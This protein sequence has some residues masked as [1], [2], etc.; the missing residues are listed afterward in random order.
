MIEV[1]IPKE[2]REYKEKWLVGMTKRQLFS[3]LLGFLVNIPLY[4]FLQQ[5]I[6][7]ELAGW[8]IILMSAPFVLIGFKT[9][10]GMPFEKLI[11]CVLLFYTT[12]QKRKYITNNIYRWIKSEYERMGEDINAK[13]TR[14]KKRKDHQ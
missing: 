12:D 11:L 4:F 14:S 5:Y 10:N 7:D 3:C 9:Y 1:R 6:G 2:V 8:L 13:K